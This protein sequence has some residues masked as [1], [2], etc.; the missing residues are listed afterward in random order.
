MAKITRVFQKIFGSTALAGEL[1]KFG[2]T[3]AGAKV[4][5]ADP[6]AI[7]SLA[8]FQAGWFAAVV[9]DD[10]PVI[11]DMNALFFLTFYQLAYLLQQGVPEWNT[12]TTYFNGSLVQDGLG[13]LYRS[14]TDTNQGNA[15]TDTTKWMT[16]GGNI[17]TVAANTTILPSDGLILS[18][19]TAAAR[20][21][22]L[23]I[24][25][26]V[27]M[28]QVITVKDKGDNSFYTEVKGNAAETVDG[29]VTFAT[30]LFRNDS[31]RVKKVS[32]TEWENV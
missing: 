22:T 24:L 9:D 14:L 20:L 7:Q 19:S 17:R 1:M 26:S 21:H 11:E 27:T 2:S 23:P 5:T 6:A 12:D 16:P 18:N 25:N 8:N 29:D 10:C 4:Y 30:K 28:G 32:T 3:A 31:L 13:T 15:L